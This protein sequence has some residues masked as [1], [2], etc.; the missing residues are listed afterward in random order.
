[1][2]SAEKEKNAML[3]QQYASLNRTKQIGLSC[4]PIANSIMENL[5]KQTEQIDSIANK[6]DRIANQLD[7]AELELNKMGSCWSCCFKPRRN[8]KTET[9]IRKLNK[10]GIKLHEQIISRP[11]DSIELTAIVTAHDPDPSKQSIPH[12]S[13]DKDKNDKKNEDYDPT[14]QYQNCDDIAPQLAE[15]SKI[16]SDL[17]EK[18]CYIGTT[19]TY[20]NNTL[21]KINTRMDD[22]INRVK[23]DTIECRKI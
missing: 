3:E 20:H 16:A 18:A 7:K 2:E 15:I 19:L 8:K 14:K 12:K 4:Q 21:N 23:K 10:N 6:N 22:N 17:S 9:K 13:T 5:D 1:M 11:H